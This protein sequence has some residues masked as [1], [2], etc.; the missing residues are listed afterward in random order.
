MNIDNKILEEVEISNSS[1]KKRTKLDKKIYELIIND[2]NNL[3]ELCKNYLEKYESKKRNYIF[4]G[5]AS[6][7]NKNLVKF[8]IDG[9]AFDAKS[10]IGDKKVKFLLDTEESDKNSLGYLNNK[11]QLFKEEMN[12]IKFL[13]Q[14]KI[15]FD[16]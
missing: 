12:A 6:E 16:S 15:E 11:F 7:A 10:S 9:E 14:K 1:P 4:S 5:G 2:I 8:K 13:M 3:I